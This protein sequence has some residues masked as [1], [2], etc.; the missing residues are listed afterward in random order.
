MR[1]ER[2]QRKP[3]QRRPIRPGS[4]P[5]GGG[6]RRAAAA[7]E[8]VLDFGA[9]LQDA[10]RRDRYRGAA[11]KNLGLRRGQSAGAGQRCGR[12][13]HGAPAAADYRRRAIG[14]PPIRATTPATS[15]ST[16]FSLY[17]GAFHAI[18]P[19][20]STRV[21]EPAKTRRSRVSGVLPCPCESPCK[22]TRSSGS[23]SAAIRRS[24]CCSRRNGAGTRSPTIR[25]PHALRDGKVS[26]SVQASPS[27]TPRAII[28]PWVRASPSSWR[29][30]TWC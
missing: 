14:S 6:P 20:R 15:A 5:F 12:G 19:R 27:A 7:C 25:G 8:R 24:R 23:T 2:P 3:L 21:F 11:A 30:L 17:P 18:S 22:W 1:P 29:G 4:R 10:G 9:A 26:A 28:S 16:S 13:R